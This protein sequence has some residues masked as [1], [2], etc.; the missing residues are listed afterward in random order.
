MLVGA[1][2]ANAAGEVPLYIAALKGH[3]PVVRLLLAHCHAHNIAWQVGAPHGHGVLLVTLISPP[4]APSQRSGSGARS[5]QGSPPSPTPPWPQDASLYG[6][7]FSP[8]MAAAVADRVDVAQALLRAAGGPS[9]AAASLVGAVNRYG[10]C[11][12]HIAAR[13]ASGRLLRLLL[14]CSCCSCSCSQCTRQQQH[15]ER[16]GEGE[17]ELGSGF[18]GGGGGGEAPGQ[19]GQRQPAHQCHHSPC[20]EEGAKEAMPP[21]SGRPAWPSGGPQH[22]NKCAVVLPDSNGDTPLDV[23]RKNRNSGALAE[24]TRGLQQLSCAV[25]HPP[26]GPAPSAAASCCSYSHHHARRHHHH[27]HHGGMLAASSGHAASM[28]PAAGVGGAKGRLGA[29]GGPATAR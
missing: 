27:H 17:G 28:G 16:G 18:N 8:L 5:H 12:L 14:S 3:L 21:W 2:V 10:Q 7:R 20:P 23:A 4:R 9:P 13:K 24:L 11:V 22:H 25:P 15:G 29:V 6:D 26:A 1:Q 19:Q